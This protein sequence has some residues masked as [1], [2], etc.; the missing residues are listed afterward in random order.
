MQ[1]ASSRRAL[2]R[3]LASTL[4]ILLSG[5][6]I[7]AAAA[8]PDLAALLRPSGVRDVRI[9][10]SGARVAALVEGPQSDSNLLVLE[11]RQGKLTNL[12]S[13]HL[14]TA[15]AIA[16]Y[17]WLSDD[18]LAIYFASPDE[19][20]AQFGIVDV[21]HHAIRVQDPFTRIVKAPRGDD[22]HIL[23]S[24]TGGNC[25]SHV[26][27]R[28]LLTIDIGS[29]S[30]NRISDPFTQGPATFLAVSASEICASGR[31][32]AGHQHDLTASWWCGPWREVRHG[33]MF[34]PAPAGQVTM[35]VS[36][37]QLHRDL[38]AQFGVSGSGQ[39]IDST[40][41][42]AQSPAKLM[43]A[44]DMNLRQQQEFASESSAFRRAVQH[45]GRQL[46]FYTAEAVGIDYVQSR[47]R[48][49]QAVITTC[50]RI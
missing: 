45:T 10:P 16:D 24:A 25:R 19:N 34:V 20:F 47:D 31:D 23:L 18:Y 5:V 35:T 6:A 37:Q 2:L 41:W 46:D 42:A 40:Q 50:S 11:E 30:T 21:P 38:P 13:T 32:G 22:T 1:H 3:A 28:C 15:N 33:R 49:L 4:I 48:L 36:N 14:G 8:T 17:Q 29:G 7:R 39:L 27:A 9:S 44:Y 26:V 43:L 12:L